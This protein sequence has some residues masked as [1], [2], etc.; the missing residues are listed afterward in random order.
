MSKS[1]LILFFG[2]S[3]CAFPWMD[4]AEEIAEDAVHDID[5]K[6]T[7]YEHMHHDV[8]PHASYRHK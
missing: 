6:V 5:D 2:L 4:T 8:K 7:E 3:S 1:I